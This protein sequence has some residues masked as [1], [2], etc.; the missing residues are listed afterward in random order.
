MGKV[1]FEL[2]NIKVNFLDEEI[3]NIERLAIHE[4]E[5]IG[6]VGRNGTGK[7]TLLRLLAGEMKP[8][9]GK[10]TSDVELGYSPQKE[11]IN[12][13]SDVDG[14]LL[15]KLL[16]SLNNENLS[17]GE[18][19]RLRW[20]ELF[21]NYHE[22]LLLDEP[23][24]HLDNNGIEFLTNHLRYYYGTLVLIS[25]NRAFL[26]EL[27][28]TIWEINNGKIQVYNGNYTQYK[29]QKEIEKEK[30]IQDYEKFRK[31]KKR[32]ETAATEKMK[33]ANKVVATNK[34][35]KNDA[36]AKPNRMNETKSKG[37]SQKA[38][39]KAAKAIEQ[40]KERLVKVENFK[41]ER[42]IKFHQ[43]KNF[44]LY[45]SAPIM[46]NGLVLKVGKKVLLDNVSFQFPLGKKIAIVGGNGV[47]KSSLLE[48][49]VDFGEGLT[50]SP[51]AKF[52]YFKQMSY[53][54]TK[55]ETVLEFLKKQSDYN[56]SFL[57]SALYAMGFVGNDLRKDVM[58]LS[59]GEIVKLHLCKLFLGKYNILLLDEPTNFLDIQ[60]IEALEKFMLSYLGTI[61]FVSHDIEFINRVS[62]IKYQIIDRKIIII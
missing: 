48:H 18:E 17:G 44:Q 1:C 59:G 62:D 61:I 25:H 23:T 2:T 36:R 11:S 43:T 12:T 47:G 10:I 27:V 5:R 41:V 20:A 38:V 19:M 56:E 33:K 45:N 29:F 35:S 7:S 13:T 15:K 42:E 49:I 31:E 39:Y 21:T 24:T 51:K 26:D 22:A 60:T 9:Y 4:F 50:I 16:V 34:L 6:I 52:G 37:S 32:L 40:R 53:R 57:K 46:A 58:E 8:T 14:M 54:F 55:S 3:L 30:Q 28:T